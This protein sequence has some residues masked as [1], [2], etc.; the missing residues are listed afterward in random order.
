M[1]NDL[2]EILKK[3]YSKYSSKLEKQ[4]HYSKIGK[5]SYLK[6]KKYGIKNFRK[7]SN[8]SGLGYSD[9]VILDVEAT[10][11]KI[12]SFLIHLI[13]FFTFG[14]IFK[15]QR[16]LN[17]R[18]FD[19]WIRYLNFIFSQ[20]QKVK[21]LLESY[22]IENSTDFGCDNKFKK[23]GKYYSP[24]YLELCNK[25]DF[26]NTHCDLKKNKTYC[27]IGGGF[28]ANI[29]LIQQNFINIKKFL[30]ID[31][32]PTIYVATKYLEKFYGKSV[33][34]YTQL[35][36]SKK[37]SFSKNNDLE[38][39]VMP[40]W[41]IDKIDVEIDHFHNG[42]SFSHL[43]IDEIKKY[44]NFLKKNKAKSFSINDQDQKNYKITNPYEYIKYFNKDIKPK[45]NNYVIEGLREGKNIYFIGEFD[46]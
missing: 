17:K 31:T 12:K 29:H 46:K 5:I 13:N 15:E 2:L 41:S 22:K 21:D 42:D 9:S 14:K 16:I 23:N 32:F 37:V 10:S 24:Y 38:I 20:N 39:I 19:N 33:I 40:S 4:N 44:L 36:N 27:E 26:I 35:V 1:N 11:G 45:K 25:L 30:L 8:G 34:S 6:I 7:S 28:G 43:K 3:D 18:I